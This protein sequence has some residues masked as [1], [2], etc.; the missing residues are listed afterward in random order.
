MATA[1]K[2]RSEPATSSKV[3]PLTRAAKPQATINYDAV[4]EEVSRRFPKIMKRLGE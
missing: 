4:H 1:P 3:K 2:S